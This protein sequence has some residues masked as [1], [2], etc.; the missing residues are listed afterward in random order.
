MKKI[1]FSA[2]LLTLT[3]GLNAQNPVLDSVVMGASYVNEVYY[4]LE[5]GTKSEQVAADWHLGFST[6]AFSVTI[7]TNAGLPSP[8]MGAPGMSVAV[9]PGGTNA[10]FETADSIGFSTWPKLFDDS[11][12]FS[13]GAFNQN[14]TGG[15]DYGWG[16]Y[17][18]ST[19]IV[20]GDSVYII[21][22]GSV[23]YKLEIVKKQSGTYTIRY[24]DIADGTGTEVEI[25]ASAYGTKDFVFF[26]LADGQI[27]DREL[28]GWDLWAV[29][30]YDW[31][32][33]A[34]TPFANQTVTGILTNPKWEV[35]VVDAGAGNQSS[36][37]D[38]SSGNFTSHKNAIGQSYKSLAGM[39]WIVTDSKVYYLRNSAGDVWK[40][41]P[42]SFVGT[43]QGKT[44]FYKQ[45][46]AFAGIESNVSEFVDIYPNP[47]KDQLTVVFDSKANNAEIIVRNQ[48]GQIVTFESLNTT[49]GVTQQKL[50]ISALNNGVY[51]VEINQNGFSTVKNVVKY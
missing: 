34:G 45:K 17:N 43:S 15:M 28:E 40:W 33:P 44:V 31:Y 8:G 2:L 5:D 39:S 51:F 9:W 4:I 23:T 13:L 11:L 22:V 50:D 42:T 18:M 10:D 27:K 24:A 3:T 26:N 47:A 46:L 1:T 41:Y 49:T 12:D 21:K 16:S 19:H 36:H 20:Q 29:K 14:A 25:P 38:F 32:G 37:V 6:D 35:A 48:M 7:T 30:Y